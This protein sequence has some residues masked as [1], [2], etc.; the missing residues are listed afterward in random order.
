MKVA[1]SSGRTKG[2]SDV[3]QILVDRNKQTNKEKQNKRVV[4]LGVK[5][6]D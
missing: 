4:S 2:E 1:V 5:A 3:A 6:K